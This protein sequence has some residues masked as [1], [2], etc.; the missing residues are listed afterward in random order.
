MYKKWLGKITNSL[1]EL[2]MKRIIKFLKP[3]DNIFF[4][5]SGL[6]KKG[7]KVLWIYLTI[8]FNFLDKKF[9]LKKVISLIELVFDKIWNFDNYL[10]RN[11]L[12]GGLFEFIYGLV[13]LMKILASIALLGVFMFFTFGFLVTIFAF[14]NSFI[15]I[16][17]TVNYLVEFIFKFLG[18]GF[19][20]LVI[21][22][23]A[24]FVTVLISLLYERYFVS[25][26]E[27]KKKKLKKR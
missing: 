11:N 13:L 17:F 5:L 3:I 4:F 20:S 2:K 19:G 27:S 18:I 24:L 15:P 9:Q 10:D 12:R 14:L 22:I 7:F 25:V 21:F 16:S 23:I 8:I 1:D 6:I 26:K